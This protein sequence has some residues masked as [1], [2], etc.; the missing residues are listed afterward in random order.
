VWRIARH[1][2]VVRL[3]EWMLLLRR[4]RE[5]AVSLSNVAT[6]RPS[7]SLTRKKMPQLAAMPFRWQDL[8]SSTA[9]EGVQARERA[10]H[11][12]HR[13]AVEP[14]VLVHRATTSARRLS[15]T[16][17]VFEEPDAPCRSRNSSLTF[18]VGYCFFQRRLFPSYF[19]VLVHGVGEATGGHDESAILNQAPNQVAEVVNAVLVVLRQPNEQVK[20]APQ[21]MT[22]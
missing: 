16:P 8:P 17:P 20:A 7:W 5:V 2:S 13:P 6:T 15:F 10:L 14:D 3:P 4:A 11:Q 21:P 22:V 9:R 19:Y 18:V 1:Q 12:R